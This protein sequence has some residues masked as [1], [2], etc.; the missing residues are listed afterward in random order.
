MD[1]YI[2]FFSVSLL[3]NAL[4]Q[5]LQGTRTPAIYLCN[6]DGCALQNSHPP[7]IGISADVSIFE[8]GFWRFRTVYIC[9][10]WAVLL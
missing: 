10:F 3:R 6:Y 7:E 8:T 2:M 1:N 4:V 5:Y 9:T